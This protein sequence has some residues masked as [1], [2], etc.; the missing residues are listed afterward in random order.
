VAI[1]TLANRPNIVFVLTDDL[2]RNLVP[3]MP[4]VR[5]M[6]RR[7]ATFTNYYVTDSLCCPSRT[8]ILTGLYPHSSGVQ[9]NTMP[10][11][12]IWKFNREGNPQR[13]F[14]V[15]L[16]GRG[17]RTALMGKYLNGYEPDQPVPAGWD[18]WVVAGNGGYGEYT[19]RLNV[20]GELVR[21]GDRPRDYMTD[22][23]S[24]HAKRFI[25]NAGSAGAEPQQPF[26]LE[27]A[28]FA[29]H[30]PYVPAPRDRRRFA[31][32]RVP[33]TPAFDFGHRARRPAWLDRPPLTRGAVQFMDHRFRR[34]VQAVQAIDRM[35]GSL[36][37]RI[38][39]LGLASNTYFVFSSDNGF[40]MGEHRLR[41]GKMT[42][43]DTD[44]RVPLVIAGP[45]IRPGMRIGALTE[46]IDL[47]PTFEDLA[48][49]TPSPSI[50]GRSLVPLLQGG[51]PAD[52][53][54]AVLVE[55]LGPD[56]DPS[57]PDF[58]RPNSG[59]PPSYNAIRLAHSLYV[60]YAD[61]TREYYETRLDPFQ[62]HNAYAALSTQFR[63]ALHRQV[64]QLVRCQ[65]GASCHRA[66]RL[67]PSPP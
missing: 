32:L 47:A 59:N 13:T 66:D 45:G 17:Y 44:I 46:N 34:R 33:H 57:D 38:R 27:V 30:S 11:G 48:G 21:H 64:K 37:R 52:W 12:G 65:G 41:P 56:L 26:L 67:L 35:V 28:T 55:H 22:V 36:Q 10:D 9:T 31:N 20:N 3:Y 54:K 2:S 7:G 60:E 14:A 18:D 15:S 19:Y 1:G 25:T 16:Q 4:N 51:T 8:S 58:P 42:A 39:S 5:S 40:H 63:R 61:G 24:R 50:E 49:H 43:F 29:P 53:R 6:M 62:L 23:L